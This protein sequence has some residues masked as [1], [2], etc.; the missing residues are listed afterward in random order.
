MKKK[1]LKT[2][3]QLKKKYEPIIREIVKERD[4]FK[5]M[6]KGINHTCSEILV[7]DHW[8]GRGNGATFFDMRNLTCICNNAN[9]LKRF[10]AYLANA[11]TRVVQEREGLG[12]L[13][14][15]NILSHKPMKFTKEQL[16]V[17]VEKYRQTYCRLD[18]KRVP[19]QA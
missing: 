2:Q 3:K 17:L 4:G 6:V 18:G 8:K 19:G 13:E 10:D 12:I 16:E 5:C 7:A 14:E 11:V 1:K 15:L 9:N